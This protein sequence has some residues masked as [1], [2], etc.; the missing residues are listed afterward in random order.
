MKKIILFLLLFLLIGVLPA[1]GKAQADKLGRAGISYISNIAD[2]NELTAYFT[3][4]F[5]V[6][7][8][9]NR[10]TTQLG[11]FGKNL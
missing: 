5:E 7:S 2:S 11:K 3:E 6:D 8:L 9:Q 4:K 10:L 1:S